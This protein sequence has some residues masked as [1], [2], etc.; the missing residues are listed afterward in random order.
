MKKIVLA[1]VVLTF[2]PSLCFATN[3]ANTKKAETVKAT[4][5]TVTAPAPGEKTTVVKAE[6]PVSLEEVTT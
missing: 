6:A 2:V 1:V 5:N 4:T 3:F